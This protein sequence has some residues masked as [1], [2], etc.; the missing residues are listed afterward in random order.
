MNQLTQKKIRLIIKVAA[1]FALGIV[2]TY[3]IYMA[4]DSNDELQ[5]WPISFQLCLW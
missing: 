2:A 4:L 5:F 1:V 3:G